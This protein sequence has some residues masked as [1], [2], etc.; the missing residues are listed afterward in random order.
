MDANTQIDIE[1]LHT[2]IV[3]AI[4]DNFPDLATVAFYLEEEDREPDFATPAC[5]LELSEFEPSPENDPGTEQ[6]AAYARFEARLIIGFRTAKAKIEI[7]KLAAAFAVF[8]RLRR[9]GLPVGPVE[10][11]TIAPDNFSPELDRFEVWRVEWRQLV[12]VGVSVW[13]DTTSTTPDEPVYSWSPDIG[14]GHEED[15]R[16][17]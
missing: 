7:R 10:V 4:T 15:Y 17:A 13:T 14:A 6:L 8:L 3:E 11:L 9:W 16:E 5:L 2:A 1:A 12:H